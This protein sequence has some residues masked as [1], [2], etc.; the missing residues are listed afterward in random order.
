MARVLVVDD[1]ESIRTALGAIVTK[2][3]HTVALA[4]DAQQGLKLLREEPFDVVVTDIILPRKSG[5][6]LLADIREIESNV[7]V[8]MITG[9]PEV[10]SA[11]EAVR[12]GAFDYLAKPISRERLTKTI[13]AA[14]EKKALIDANIRLEEENRKHRE[15]LEQLVDER[16]RQIER[17][18]NQQRHINN[19]ALALGT[20][21]DVSQI[22]NKVHEEL[23]S[24]MNAESFI[25]SFVDEEGQ[26]LQAGY[27]VFQQR[28]YDVSKLPPIPL[29]KKGHGTQSEVIHTG[30]PLY[31]PTCR[32][33]QE[34]GTTEYNIDD[35]GIMREGPPP[36]EAEDVA[37][38]TLFV[39]MKVESKTIGVMQIQ[40]SRLDAYTQ[41]DIDLFAG[42][43]NVSA[44]AVRNAQLL[45]E[46]AADAKKL[47]TALDATI[48]SLGAA[49]GA[50]D[51]YTADHQ[52][53]VT[54]LAS[55]IAGEMKLAAEKVKGLRVAGLLH[56][57]GKISIPA[58][59]LSKPSRLTEMEF[60]LLR[61]HPR[62]AH[63]ILSG[64]NFAW[65]VE[66]IVLQH[67]ERLDGSGYPNGLKGDE[68]LLEARI[69]GVADVVEAMSSHRPYRPALGIDAACE[70]IK[71]KKGIQY[72]SAVVDACIQLFDAGFSF[73]DGDVA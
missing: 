73:S 13:T 1:E 59:I 69:L 72:D 42:L 10:K 66:D 7:Q 32:K 54:E 17:L 67:H 5:V 11:A 52:K 61:T 47:G 41:E 48:A 64:I 16:T 71:L 2:S 25:V 31:V 26:F 21:Q 15:H 19:L 62:V 29:E 23:S 34:I 8:I 27:A 68:I 33:P 20:V 70:E 4:C 3:G 30:E 14:V 49:I 60:A 43:A 9:E 28:P 46:V 37:R 12:R 50:R 6:Q 44:V 57:V 40:S 65:P 24:L 45:E 36:E 56:D 51:P 35:D 18:L 58:E 22:Y 63:D 55:A 38:S 53:R 39:P